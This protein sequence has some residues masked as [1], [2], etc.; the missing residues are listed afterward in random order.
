MMLHKKKIPSIMA[1]IPS[2]GRSEHRMLMRYVPRFKQVDFGDST[3]LTV[4][5][6]KFITTKKKGNGGSFGDWDKKEQQFHGIFFWRL[7]Q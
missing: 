1:S 4:A 3:D 5:V 7:D 2:I 6:I